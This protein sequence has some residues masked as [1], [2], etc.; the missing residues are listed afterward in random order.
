MTHYFDRLAF[1]C[2]LTGHERGRVVV[3]YKALEGDKFM[4]YDA[5]F[6]DLPAISAEADR[7]LALLEAGAPARELPP[8]PPWMAKFC[9]FA[10]QCGCG[11][12]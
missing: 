3:Y 7:R 8:C 12:R 6:K 5:I 9:N 11:D 2:A 1:E 4:V 10:P